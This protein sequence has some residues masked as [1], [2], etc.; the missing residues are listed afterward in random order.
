[1]IE[2][3]AVGRQFD[4]RPGQEAAAGRG[5]WAWPGGGGRTG[6]LLSTTPAIDFWPGPEGAA[7]GRAAGRRYF[8]LFHAPP[9]LGLARM[10]RWRGGHWQLDGEFAVYASRSRLRASPGGVVEGRATLARSLLF[11][12]SLTGLSTGLGGPAML[13]HW[14]QHN[15]RL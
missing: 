1:M 5:L 11:Y 10:E 8:F 9:T 7:A 6:S 13:G 14:S 15:L 3:D 2:L 4:F 12:L